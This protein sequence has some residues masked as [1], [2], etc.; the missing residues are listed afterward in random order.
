MLCLG[1]LAFTDSY[2]TFDPSPGR[3]GGS[4]GNPISLS[5]GR[6]QVP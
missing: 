1:Q 4:A 6:L 2:Q 3:D 5:P